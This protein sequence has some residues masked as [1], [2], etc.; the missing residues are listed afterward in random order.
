M[1]NGVQNKQSGVSSESPSNPPNWATSMMNVNSPEYQATLEKN[2]PKPV[3]TKIS[4]VGN[5]PTSIQASPVKGIHNIKASVDSWKSETAKEKARW[6]AL[7]DDQK[8]QEIEQKNLETERERYLKNFYSGYGGITTGAVNIGLG[9]GEEGEIAGGFVPGLGEIID[10]KNTIQDLSKGDYVGAGLNAAGLMIPFV[11]GKT[12]KKGAEW[13]FGKKP[14]PTPPKLKHEYWKDD[15]IIDYTSKGTSPTKVDTRPLQNKKRPAW[16]DENTKSPDFNLVD[17]LINETSTPN[18]Q[19]RLKG[20]GIEHPEDF[21]MHAR[22]NVR[23]IDKLD[24]GGYYSP[25]NVAGTPEVN[26]GSNMHK[27]H[28]EHW[29]P[30]KD[31]LTG[32]H[33]LH[34]HGVQDYIRKQDNLLAGGNVNDGRTW[35]DH[36][37][38][39]WLKKEAPDS[40]FIQ[41]HGYSNNPSTDYLLNSRKAS[42]GSVGGVTPRGMEIGWSSEPLAHLSEMRREMGIALDRPFDDIFSVDDINKFASTP[43]GKKNR[44]LGTGVPRNHVL[45]SF[46]DK[47]PSVA[48]G[49]TGAGAGYGLLRGQ[50]NEQ[51]TN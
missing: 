9:S 38:Q 11:G 6:D 51:K 39:D 15:P 43:L 48:L 5:T 46:L 32:S 40:W 29:G 47:A 41:K 8:Q 19:R 45:A 28:F 4:A 3:N 7:T 25:S 26:I 31:Y 2:T 44:I 24:E 17:R 35:V 33:E 42:Q 20:L 27:D 1:A 22:G 34:G 12:L 23:Y 21:T 30:N 13:L 16:V 49:V 14:K 37:F 18:S 50:R 36:D 10:T